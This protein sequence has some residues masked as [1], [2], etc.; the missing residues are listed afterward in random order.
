MDQP[1]SPLTDRET[2]RQ[3][4]QLLKLAACVSDREL[5]RRLEE[6]AA[7]LMAQGLAGLELAQSR[8]GAI[9]PA[10]WYSGG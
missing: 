2:L 8:D 5:A 1:W 9:R 7:R 10:G 6:Q 3:S 4:K